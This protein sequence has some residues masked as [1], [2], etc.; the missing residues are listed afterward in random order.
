[1]Y[2]QD[3][4][5]DELSEMDLPQLDAVIL[6]LEDEVDSVQA[7]IDNSKLDLGESELLS[8]LVARE[9]EREYWET[10][11]RMTKKLLEVLT[12][13]VCPPEGEVED[14]D[15]EIEVTTTLLQKLE[16]ILTQAKE[17]EEDAKMEMVVAQHKI[18][19]ALEHKWKLE[20]KL[21]KLQVDRQVLF[22]KQ[23]QADAPPYT[24]LSLRLP[25]NNAT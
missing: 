2:S 17:K 11:V 4:K 1:M 7:F 22:V 8:T 12:D 6:K 15:Y 20:A 13:T 21:L 9:L 16:P 3:N 24:F 10:E 5:E 18:E 14:I 25:N 19:V 23:Q